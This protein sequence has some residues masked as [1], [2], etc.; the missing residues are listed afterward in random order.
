AVRNCS[1]SNPIPDDDESD[2]GSEPDES[3][4]QWDPPV[5]LHLYNRD[6]QEF[7][8]HEPRLDQLPSDC[9]FA[10]IFHT[11]E[12]YRGSSL[13]R[14]MMNPDQHPGY[15]DAEQSTLHEVELQQGHTLAVIDTPPFGGA[16]STDDLEAN[17][18]LL[19]MSGLPL[20]RIYF[21][22]DATRRYHDLQLQILALA[23]FYGQQIASKL[24]FVVNGCNFNV[25]QQ[26][27]SVLPHNVKW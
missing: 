4:Y 27:L 23:T 16:L 10:V 18:N 9:N 3:L 5:T 24:V 7:T 17:R 15:K 13:L 8:N 25:D 22:M 11:L 12:S 2:P 21:V 6:G 26:P 14:A 1:E 19:A 20:K